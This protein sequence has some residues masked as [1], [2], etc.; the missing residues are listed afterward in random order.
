MAKQVYTRALKVTFLEKAN[1]NDRAFDEVPQWQR[2]PCDEEY[3]FKAVEVLH[4]S[5]FR[6][7]PEHLEVKLK[8][9][10]A[11][12]KRLYS[13]KRILNIEVMEQVYDN[14]LKK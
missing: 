3:F 11:Y 13:K 5:Q 4:L 1:I 10:M 2:V 6:I 14:L 7:K 12:L 9:R 8:E